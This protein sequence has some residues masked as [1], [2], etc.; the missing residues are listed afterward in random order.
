VENDVERGD[1]LGVHEP[2]HG[3]ATPGGGGDVLR[4]GDRAA[5]GADAREV[6]ADDEGAGGGASDGD[7]QPPP[8]AAP[9]SST[10]RAV[11]RNRKDAFSWSSLMAARLR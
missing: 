5:D 7:L 8:G 3:R 9:R 11:R 1:A 6:D 2:P 4:E 10:A